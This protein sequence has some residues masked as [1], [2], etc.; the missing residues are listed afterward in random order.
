M[1]KKNRFWKY[2][3]LGAAALIGL[4][5]IYLLFSISSAPPEEA[6]NHSIKEIV[7]DNLSNLE[8]QY[9]R[10]EFLAQNIMYLYTPDNIEDLEPMMQVFESFFETVDSLNNLI[11]TTMYAIDKSTSSNADQPQAHHS[12][13]KEFTQKLDSLVSELT[14]AEEIDFIDNYKSFLNFIYFFDQRITGGIDLDNNGE[15]WGK[16]DGIAIN[17][18]INNLKIDFYNATLEYL[19]ELRENYI[20]SPGDLVYRIYPERFPAW[21][22][23]GGHHRSMWRIKS[24]RNPTEF[25]P[26]TFNTDSKPILLVEGEKVDYEGDKIA[27][28][29]VVEKTGRHEYPSELHVPFYSKVKSREDT[30]KLDGLIKFFGG[31]KSAAANTDNKNILFLGQRQMVKAYGHCGYLICPELMSLSDELVIE[32][33]QDGEFYVTPHAKG[34]HKLLLR[35]RDLFIDNLTVEV[36]RAPYTVSILPKE[37]EAMVD[38]DFSS[39]YGL[40]DSEGLKNCQVSEFELVY[41]RQGKKAEYFPVKGNRI[42]SDILQLLAEANPKDQVLIQNAR[43]SCPEKFSYLEFSP[44]VLTGDEVGFLFSPKENGYEE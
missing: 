26:L 11:F 30:F 27:F 10:I 25:L 12:I 13:L 18:Y 35:D 23:K 3:F 42:D 37:G 33:G 8:N 39:S 38:F 5:V 24:I 43:S 36:I 6:I 17:Y 2:A 34:T 44:V 14:D 15:Y 7:S 16:L 19:N 22:Y 4:R 1:G 28:S 29:T 31:N 21:I 9:L 32:N 41:F 40:S 20:Y